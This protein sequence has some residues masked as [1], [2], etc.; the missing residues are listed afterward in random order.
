MAGTIKQDRLMPNST[1][2]NMDHYRYFIVLQPQRL[3]VG[4][5]TL[6]RQA[7]RAAAFEFVG[8]LQEWTAE[9]DQQD[10]VSALEV[11]MFGQIQI[12]CSPEFIEQIRQQDILAIAEI[13]AAQSIE[14]SLRRV[15]EQASA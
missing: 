14:T 15:I 5:F 8:L 6:Q 10:Q 2:T 12:T 11:T 9:R 4:P 1:A 3:P 7:R 13:R